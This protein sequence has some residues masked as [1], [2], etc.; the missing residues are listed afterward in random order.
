MLQGETKRNGKEAL[1]TSNISL[2]I[3]CTFDRPDFL[4]PSRKVADSLASYLHSSSSMCPNFT[5]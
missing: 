5:G 2:L 4:S 1:P 3:L